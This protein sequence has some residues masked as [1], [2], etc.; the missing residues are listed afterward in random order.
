MNWAIGAHPIQAMGMGGREVRGGEGNIY[1][2]FAVDFEYPDGVHVLS[3]CRHMDGCTERVSERVM[4][5]TGWAYTDG[6]DGFI[7]GQNPYR[8]DG[9]D[10]NPYE[11]EHVDLIESIRAGEPLNE[12]RQVADHAVF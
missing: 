8:Y 10:V 4:G 9:Q 5:T 1:D 2:H 11:Q 7:E 3:M 6:S 12:G